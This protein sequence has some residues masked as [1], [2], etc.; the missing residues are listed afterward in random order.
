MKA[1]PVTDRRIGNSLGVVIPKPV[2]AL[3][4]LSDQAEMTIERGA[5]DP[6]VRSEIRKSRPCLIVSPPEPN[7]HLRTVIVAPLTS[8]GFAAPFLRR[9]CQQS[10]SHCR[11]CLPS[12]SRETLMEAGLA[13]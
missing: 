9:P 2:L 13:P 8:K 5:D 12:S 1:L 4:G 7:Q 3:A 6:T 11:M 10:W